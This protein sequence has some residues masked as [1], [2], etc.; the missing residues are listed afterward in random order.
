MFSKVVVGSNYPI[1]S[2]AER[3]FPSK[4]VSNAEIV[5]H[6]FAKIARKDAE[7]ST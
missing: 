1:F 7:L 4:R 6:G 3:S 2:T 5:T